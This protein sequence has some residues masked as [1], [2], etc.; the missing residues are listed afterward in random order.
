LYDVRRWIHLIREL[1]EQAPDLVITHLWF[2]NCIGRIAA[3]IARVPKVVAFEHNIYTEVK[4]WKQFFV[5]RVLQH[6][7]ANIIA[8]SGSVRDSLITHGI[9]PEKI[10]VLRN[11][12][13]LR[14]YTQSESVTVRREL[15]LKEKEFVFLSIGRLTRQKGVD[16]VLHAF[17]HTNGGTLLIVGDGEDRSELEKLAGILGISSR[18]H[19]MG[20]RYD[21]PNFLQSADCFILLSRWE[22]VGIVVLEAMATGLPVIVSD[23]DAA[24]EFVQAG[25]DGVIVPRE[26]PIAVSRAMERIM[27]NASV[28]DSLGRNARQSAKQFSIKRHVDG[29]MKYIQ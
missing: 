10:L 17:S 14:R 11:G 28:R 20:I 15:N 22:G 18:V 7:S 26:D 24:L 8:V 4:S 3:Y 2:A 19:F 13:D 1:R 16:V 6:L 9:K 21:V 5:D 23:F 29:I 27:N 12:I 25:M